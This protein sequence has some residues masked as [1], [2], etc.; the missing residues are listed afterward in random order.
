MRRQSVHC[1]SQYINGQNSMLKWA[2]ILKKKN[3]LESE[4]SGIFQIYT[5]C[6]KFLQIK[7]FFFK[8]SFKGLLKMSRAYKLL[9]TTLCT[10]THRVLNTCTYKILWN[11]VLGF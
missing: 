9:I 1:Y 2:N 5:S 3:I 10:N 6:S 4:L 11:S 7:V 8:I